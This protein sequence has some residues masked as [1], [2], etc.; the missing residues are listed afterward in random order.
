MKNV[1]YSEIVCITLVAMFA[2]VII[3]CDKPEDQPPP[4]PADDRVA[5]Q[6]ALPAPMFKGT[7]RPIK[8]EPNMGPARKGKRP[9]FMA[10]KGTVNLA[11]GKTVKSSDP[12]PIIGELKFVTDGEKVGEEGYFVELA[13][14]KQWITIDLGGQSE[15]CAVVLWH[16]HQKARAYRDVVIQISR[17]EGFSEMETVFNND[18]DNSAGQ[19]KGKDKGYVEDYQGKF[20]DA[21]GVRGRYVRLWS[22][23]NTSNE[24]NHYI[25]VEVYGKP[26]K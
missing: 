25:E 7:P 8:G 3:G 26:L 23:E 19:G 12:A 21:R 22:M 18:H 11:A 17:D 20:V 13:P 6:I 1:K 14:G 15:I 5:L 4:G 24:S 2:A 9:P 16:Y 10:P